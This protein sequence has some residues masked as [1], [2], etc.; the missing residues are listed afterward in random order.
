[1]KKLF[2]AAGMIATLTIASCKKDKA[3]DSPVN[4]DS[5]LLSKVTSTEGG[6]TSTYTLSYDANKHLT[7]IRSSDDVE[8]TSF[9]YDANGNLTRVEDVDDNFKNIYT[10]TYT[11]NVPVSGTFKSL[12]KHAG[13]PEELIEDDRLTYTVTNNQVT[14]IHLD[15]NLAE[16]EADFTLAYANG[17][18]SKVTMD[19]TDM[20]TAEFTFGTK[21]S[22]YPQLSKYVLD[23]AGFSLQ[24]ACKNELLK[25][26]YDFP[27]TELDKT[28]TNQY[29]YDSKGNVLTST[30][31]TTTLKFEYQ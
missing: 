26:K 6:Q 30:D 14:K 4:N 22:P 3:D 9:T 16:T 25:A 17:N 31:G 1:M 8:V 19:G 13:E 12:K 21:R 23:Q 2:L 18:L 10:Y 27:G 5:R 15:M 28:L 24:F 29:T 7:S 20:Y 11:N